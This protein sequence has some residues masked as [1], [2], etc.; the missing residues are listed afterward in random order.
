M[1]IRDEYSPRFGRQRLTLWS[2]Q[3][4]SEYEGEA[5]ELPGH[6]GYS[7]TTFTGAKVR[8]ECEAPRTEDNY[9]RVDAAINQAVKGE[10]VT[11]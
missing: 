7:V 2:G 11:A 3:F 4:A 10:P 6:N 1:W 9:L 8:V 5:I